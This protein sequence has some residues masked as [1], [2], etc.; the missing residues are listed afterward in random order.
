T[1]FTMILAMAVVTTMV[2]PPMLRWAVSRV[3]LRPDE[4]ERLEREAFEAEGFVT[5]MERLLVAVDKSPNG[6]FAS[7]LT[8]LLAA[9]RRLPPRIIMRAGGNA[10]R[11]RGR[12]SGPARVE[13]LA[14]ATAEAAQPEGSDAQL[15]PAPVDITARRQPKDPERAISEEAKKG[16]DFLIIGVE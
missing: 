8:G 9:S 14:K 2:M 11:R 5:T 1:L 10:S 12:G 4:E 6:R 7:R 16:Y 15:A 13:A 3:P